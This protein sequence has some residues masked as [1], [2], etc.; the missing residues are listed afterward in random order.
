MAFLRVAGIMEKQTVNERLVE[1]KCFCGFHQNDETLRHSAS[2]GLA[3]ALAE[4]TISQG[5]V[6]YGVIHAAAFDGAEY[7]RVLEQKDLK[8]IQG[9]KYV[10]VNPIC[11]GK[12]VYEMVLSDLREGRIVL[13]TGLP[14]MV[15]AVVKRAEKEALSKNLIA[16]DLVC[17]GPTAPVVAKEYAALMQKKH[18]SEVVDIQVRHKKNGEWIPP[19]L[20]VVYANGTSSMK[21]FT[22]TEYAFAFRVLAPKRCY[23][24]GFKGEKHLSDL[25]IGDYWGV[26]KKEDGY[27]NQGVSVAIAHTTRGIQVLEGL[28]NFRSFEISYKKA[29]KG[30]PYYEKTRT[31]DS[32]HQRFEELLRTKG[33]KAACNRCMTPKEKLRQ[34]IPQFLIN[35]LHRL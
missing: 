11:Q 17:H 30:N 24:C 23:K 14:C 8:S 3:T 32:R 21:P 35:L 16:V 6:V 4:E 13:F 18:R 28:K 22:A 7:A 27:N 25:T 26:D 33:L 10:D 31:E 12:N 29:I 34:Y 1:P 20:K 2:G 9:T 5:G 19:Y 15:G